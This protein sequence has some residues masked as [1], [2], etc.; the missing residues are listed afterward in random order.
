VLLGADL[1]DDVGG[2]ETGEAADY[3]QIEIEEKTLDETGPVGIS[4]AGGVTDD[5]GWGGGGMDP[6]TASAQLGTLFAI[7]DDDELDAA[8][9]GVE[10]MASIVRPVLRSIIANS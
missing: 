3:L 7:G 1:L 2:G 10:A 8:G 9:D 6:A 5:L 4:C